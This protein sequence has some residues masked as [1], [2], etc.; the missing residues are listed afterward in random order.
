ML[1]AS[2][3]WRVVYGALA[4]VNTANLLAVLGQYKGIPAGDGTIGGTLNDWSVA[5]R[6]ATWFDGLIW[7]IA[8][9]GV[10]TGLVMIWALLQMRD[11]AAQALARET[12]S[13]AEDPEAPAWWLARASVPGRTA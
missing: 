9:S 5:I 6:T 2:W 8:L 13:R 4:V 7:P 1:A 12:A 3:R 10:V 11:R